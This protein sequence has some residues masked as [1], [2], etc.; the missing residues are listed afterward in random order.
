MFF[1]FYDLAYTPM[2]ISY[3]LE[4]L[5]YNIRAR[6]L[7]IMNFTAYL[8]NAFNVFVN[9]WALGAIGWKYY[10]VFCG[11]L[12]VELV[13]V[14]LFIVETKDRTLEETAALFDG[15]KPPGNTEWKDSLTFA[16]TPQ[17]RSPRVDKDFRDNY[18]E[19]H[20]SSGV[21]ETQ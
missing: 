12:V 3:T 5:P 21:S 7:A 11:W 17:P 8:S 18:F 16:R 13:I 19:L 20:E 2:V 1:F 4:I 14:M 10:L 9:P 6:G 15:V